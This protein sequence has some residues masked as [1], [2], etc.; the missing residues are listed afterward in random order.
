[1]ARMEED[2]GNK[3]GA[4]FDFQKAQQ[5]ASEKISDRLERFETKLDRLQLETAHVRL[6]K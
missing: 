3:I 2:L 5:D 1:M 6:V 4:L